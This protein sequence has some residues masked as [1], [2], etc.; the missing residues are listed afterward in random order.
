[1][2]ETNKEIKQLCYQ[3]RDKLIERSIYMNIAHLEEK[4]QENKQYFQNNKQLKDE[5]FS[6]TV[7]FFC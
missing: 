2:K 7:C 3:N 6:C 5:Q 4:Q 1:M